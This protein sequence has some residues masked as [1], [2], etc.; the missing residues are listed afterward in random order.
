M[1][2]STTSSGVEVICSKGTSLLFMSTFYRRA[3]CAAD[4]CAVLSENILHSQS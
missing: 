1:L 3:H 2:F 4:Y